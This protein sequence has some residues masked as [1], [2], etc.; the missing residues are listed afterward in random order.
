MAITTVTLLPSTTYGTPSGNY[1]G[2]S[3]DFIGDPQKAA[4]YYRGRGGTQTIRWVYLGVQGKVT[5]QA[6]LDNDPA[7]SRWFEVAATGDGS[8]DD[9]TTIT[10]TYIEAVVGNFV[11]LR[12]VVSNFKDGTIEVVQATY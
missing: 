5:I 12:A 7:D 2:S 8:T 11:W 3:E 4:N 6:T 1:D 10:A 9:S